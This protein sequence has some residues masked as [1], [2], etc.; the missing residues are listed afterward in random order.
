V[1]KHHPDQAQ[2]FAKVCHALVTCRKNPNFA[3]EAALKFVVEK[4][5]L[6]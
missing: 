3:D 6:H 1:K 4:I 5:P 2:T